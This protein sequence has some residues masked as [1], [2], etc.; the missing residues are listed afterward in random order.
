M[1]RAV[2][3]LQEENVEGRPPAAS[4]CTESMRG[5]T[6]PKECETAMEEAVVRPEQ[7][8]RSSSR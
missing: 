6:V 7:R 5:M 2:A 3:M 1:R 8:V 4:G